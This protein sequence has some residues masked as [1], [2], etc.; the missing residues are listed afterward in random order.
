MTSDHSKKMTFLTS[1]RLSYWVNKGYIKVTLPKTNCSFYLVTGILC[2]VR[3]TGY[4]S[5]GMHLI[6]VSFLIG[7][8]VIY[9]S[10]NAGSHFLAQVS[11]LVVRT[12]TTRWKQ[13]LV[14]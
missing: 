14:L 10:L 1:I 6:Y 11:G 2:V 5:R 4:H 9:S 8:Q 3:M 13:M 12:A 7:Q